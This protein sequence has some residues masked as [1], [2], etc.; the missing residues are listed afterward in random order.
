[1]NFTVR[2]TPIVDAVLDRLCRFGADRGLF[3]ALTAALKYA[4]ALDPYTSGR[5]LHEGLGSIENRPLKLI[6][7]IDGP[8][9]IVKIVG[10]RRIP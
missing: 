1:M 9:R 2:T 10:A 7:E 8:N 5:F 3:I 6:Y 4:L